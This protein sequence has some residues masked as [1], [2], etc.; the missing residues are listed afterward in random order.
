MVETSS[1]ATGI[2]TIF[3][4]VAPV[5]ILEQQKRVPGITHSRHPFLDS[6]PNLYTIDC[7]AAP[8]K[9]EPGT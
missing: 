9:P 8:T 3:P 2:K 7:A 6:N 1:T 4:A 5:Q